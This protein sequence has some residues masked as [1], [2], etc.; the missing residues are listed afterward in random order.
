[1]NPPPLIEKA[2]TPAIQFDDKNEAVLPI[3]DI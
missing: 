3:F 2:S 1:M